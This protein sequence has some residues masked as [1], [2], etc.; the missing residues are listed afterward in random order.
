MDSDLLASNEACSSESTSF[1]KA[2]TA[3]MRSITV[4]IFHSKRFLHTFW[5]FVWKH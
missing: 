2:G 1:S 4:Y 3:F 5:C